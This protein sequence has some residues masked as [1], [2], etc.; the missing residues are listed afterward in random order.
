M[1]HNNGHSPFLVEELSIVYNQ[2]MF[3]VLE[4]SSREEKGALNRFVAP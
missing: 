3:T 1:V 2:H 4:R